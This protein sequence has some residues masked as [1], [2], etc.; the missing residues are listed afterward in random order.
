MSDQIK[1]LFEAMNEKPVAFHR[2]YAQ[3]TGSITAGLLLSQLV[4]WDKTCKGKEFYKTDDDFC[5]EL[6]MGLYELRGAKNKVA[7][8]VSI[9]R[10]GIPAKT[11]YKVD[12]M[13]IINAITSCGKNPELVVG[14]TQNWLWEKPRTGCGKNP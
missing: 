9:K 14:K 6:G 12:K 8:F 5:Q 1:E 11:Y 4:Y 7:Q 13:A 3:I 2:V 10:K